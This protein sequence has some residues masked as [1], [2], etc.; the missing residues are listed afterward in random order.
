MDSMFLKEGC[1]S[2]DR[3]RDKA[4]GYQMES[5]SEEEKVE[6]YRR[7]RKQ[8]RTDPRGFIKI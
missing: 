1:S 2:E 3:W 6:F 8:S 4:E 5:G 7:T